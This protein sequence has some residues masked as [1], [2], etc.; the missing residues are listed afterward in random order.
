MEVR[1]TYWKHADGHSAQEGDEDAI[2]HVTVLK[3]ISESYFAGLTA[4][5]YGIWSA[6]D[7][8]S[9]LRIER[10]N[11]GE[12]VQMD[13]WDIFNAYHDHLRHEDDEEVGDLVVTFDTADAI[14]RGHDDDFITGLEYFRDH[15]DSNV[16]FQE[17]DEDGRELTR[18]EEYEVELHRIT[19]DRLR[20]QGLSDD[21]I[22]NTLGVPRPQ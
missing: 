16:D 11:N 4:C 18:V 12:W 6:D 19:I 15:I 20:Q 21:Q 13:G 1:I 22:A 9:I 14:F 5:P 7:G 8:D 10:R 17:V 2:Q 3:G